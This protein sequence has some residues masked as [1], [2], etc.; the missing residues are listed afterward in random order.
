MKYVALLRGINVGGN[1]KVSMLELKAMFEDLGFFD[2]QTYI[3]S[4]N[5]I[6]SGKQSRLKKVEPAFV[7]RFGFPIKFLFVDKNK[8]KDIH[9]TI[10]THWTNDAKQKTD[11]WFLW[12]EYADESSLELLSI[13]CEVDEVLYVH[14]AII[15]HIL[16]SDYSKSG[17]NDIIG[18]K[19]Y[20]NLAARNVNTV[21]KIFKLI[22]D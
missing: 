4:G 20:K 15:W 9:D 19:L 11:V 12:D 16:R 21:R 22:Q 2:V 10:P 3:N 8:L 6:F 5:V 13:N 18:S 1:N 14:G 7:E 17:L